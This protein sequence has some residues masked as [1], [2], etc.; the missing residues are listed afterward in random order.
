[1]SEAPELAAEVAAVADDALLDLLSVEW[2][3]L[4]IQQARVWAVMAEIPTSSSTARP[5]RSAPSWC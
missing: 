2:Q 5:T 1:M 3:R 4:C